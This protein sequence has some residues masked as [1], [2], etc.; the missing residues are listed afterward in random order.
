MTEEIFFQCIQEVLN[1]PSYRMNMQRLSRLHRDA[2]MKPMDSALFWIE[3]VMRHKGAAHLRTE[4]YRLPWYSYHS[5]D[6]MLFLAGITLLIFMTFAAL[7]SSRGRVKMQGLWLWMALCFLCP[8]VVHGGKVLVFPIDGSHWVNMKYIIEALHSR[9]HQVSVVRPS[10]SWYI[11]EKSPF[12]NS[13]T[14]D[15]PSE[16]DESFI[17]T[18]IARL[19]EIQREGKSFW[20]RYKLEIEQAEMTGRCTDYISLFQA[21]DLW[22]MRVD[23]VYEYPRPTMPNVVYIGGMNM[24]RLSRL[25][26][27]APMK[28][29]DSA[30]FWI[31]FVMRHKGAAHLRTESYRLPWYS[32]HSRQGKN[33][34]PLVVDGSML[35]LP[36][37]GPRWES[38]LFPIDGSHWVNMK[39]II[40]ALHS[41]GHQV[42]VMRS[43]DSWYIEE[44]S[45]FYNSITLGSPSEFDESFI[46]TFIARLLEI[47]REGKSIWTRY[48]LEIEQAE[49]T[50]EMYEKTSEFVEML[51][52]NK[53]LMQSIKNTNYDLVFTD[54][55]APVGAILANYLKL[56]L[57]FNA[58]WTSHAADLWL[59]R[60]DFVFEYPRPTMPNV[61]Y[62]GGF[63]CKPAKPLPEHLEEFVQSSGEHGV[64]VMSLGTFIAE[65][66]QDLVDQIAAAFAKMPQKVI[67]RYKGA[68]PATLGNNTLLVDW[69]PQ[70]DLLGHPKTKLLWLMEEQTE[71]RKLSITES[72]SLNLL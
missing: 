45:P 30:L 63:Q 59:M 66:P 67:W 39:V 22:L 69:M 9:G 61:V 46:T 27:D 42:S 60:V 21:A 55:V 7:I 72:P 18:F 16:F 20:T 15:S 14:L 29:M 32:Y 33:A 37:R 2:P 40:E 23:F 57:V 24:Q 50:R 25:H 51:L 6:V 44:K 58:R 26:R 43:S 70:N 62:I 31:E 35:P 65:L 28:P 54:P 71:F 34:G 13:I 56:P 36:D 19:L 47:Q 64:T 17:T 8:T 41:R 49:M 3:F 12:Y 68:K 38:S 48:K 5:V 53:D 1:D 52:E 10:D 4:S 11:E